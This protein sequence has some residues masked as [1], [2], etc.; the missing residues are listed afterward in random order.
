MAD[1]T[2]RDTVEPVVFPG[3]VSKR[4]VLALLMVS[5]A[6]LIVSAVL[7]LHGG[8]AWDWLRLI[9]ALV[10]GA[11]TLQLLNTRVELGSTALVL[12]RLPRRRIPYRDI[13]DVHGDTADVRWSQSLVLKLRDGSRRR[14]APVTQ[15]VPLRDALLARIRA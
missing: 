6:Y 14:I 10:W 7:T 3:P 2:A 4:W 9:A 15:P 5:P 12:G 11:L 8:D 13:A 1:T